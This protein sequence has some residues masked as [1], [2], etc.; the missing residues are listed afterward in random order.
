MK[1]QVHTERVIHRDPTL[2]AAKEGRKEYTVVVEAPPGEVVDFIFDLPKDAIVEEVRINEKLVGYEPVFAEKI[3]L[4]KVP[5]TITHKRSAFVII[6]DYSRMSLPKVKDFFRPRYVVEW[7]YPETKTPFTLIR[8]P[9]KDYILDR[10]GMELNVVEGKVVKIDNLSDGLINIY[11]EFLSELKLKVEKGLSYGRYAGLWKNEYAVCHSFDKGC[12]S[13]KVRE[14][15]KLDT[16][17][18]I[19]SLIP[20]LLLILGL[21][22]TFNS[23]AQFDLLIALTL[24]AIAIVISIREFTL[25]GTRLNLFCTLTLYSPIIILLLFLS[26]GL[27]YSIYF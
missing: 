14:E 27:L 26:F 16:I 25:K 17:P 24:S 10:Q 6:C 23:K 12:P 9:M 19:L 13:I 7:F 18:Y 4:Y 2:G 1:I 11:E 5:L 21:V 20:M 8:I 3:S 15:Y 22:L